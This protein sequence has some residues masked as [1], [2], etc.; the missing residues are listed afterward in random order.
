MRFIVGV[1]T[2]VLVG[3][4][5]LVAGQP[6]PQELAD[7]IDLH[8]AE[9][10]KSDK[11]Q[12]APLSDDS[13]FLRRVFLDLTGRIPASRD[14]H[15]FLADGS[16]D[17]RA[18]IIDALL[19][20]PRHAI[21]FSHVWRALLLPEVEASGDARFFQSGFETW[22]RE[23]RRLRVPYDQL[24]YDLV[25]TPIETRADAAQP[26]FGQ[27]DH[28]NPLAFFAVKDARPENLAAATTRLFLGVQLECAQCHDHPFAAWTQDQFWNQAAFF[29][30]IERQGNGIFAPLLESVDRHEVTPPN[31]TR[32]IPAVFL[33]QKGAPR[34]TKKNARVALARWITAADNPYF[35]RAAVNRFWSQFFGIG[36]VQPVDDFR[37]GHPPSHPKL[38]DDLTRS[39]VAARFD[40][41]YLIS[42]ICRSRGYQLSSAVTQ[43]RVTDPRQF[44]RG[45]VKPLSGDQFVDSLALAVGLGDI[46]QLDSYT[47]EPNARR[48]QLRKQ[49]APR[50]SG[51]EPETSILQALTLMNGKIANQATTPGESA[52]LTA[53]S[54]MPLADS[55]ARIEA[56]YVAALSR[57]PT[58]KESE[59]LVAYVKR[60][61]N[62]REPERLAD[63][64]WMLLNSAEFR[65][66]H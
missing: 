37:D 9:R 30:G 41:D 19:A 22:L 16:R 4:T 11:I 26:V 54:E 13:E 21:H 31:G 47:G 35:A 1:L 33:D 49:F 29:A 66:N 62:S 38:L 28:A 52:T 8:L 14:V 56:L 59:A 39:F 60:V 46:R 2:A 18:R 43:S 63:V 51:S 65:V 50:G 34:K 53:V 40:L 20:S 61:D 64:F 10:W 32:A 12:A 5:S 48:D 25:A 45:A 7:R 6:S 55:A 42:A 44:A 36:I 27:S 57:K 15:E 17:K 3:A 24:V 23:R 58:A